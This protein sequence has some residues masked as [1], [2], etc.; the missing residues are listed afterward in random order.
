MHLRH[1]PSILCAGLLAACSSAP[2]KDTLATLRNV[3]ADTADVQE[4]GR[5]HV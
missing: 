3:P 5:A 4:I 2:D 1:A